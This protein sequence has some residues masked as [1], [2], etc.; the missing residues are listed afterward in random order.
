MSQRQLA[1]RLI[2]GVALGFILLAWFISGLEWKELWGVLKQVSL[3]WLLVA[4]VLMLLDYFFQAW[5]WG[6]L[7]RHVDDKISIKDLWNATAVMWAFNTLL[8]LRAGN[9]LRPALI[10][11]RRG[12]PYTTVL[13]T[14]VAEYIC[15]VF[16]ILIMLLT[17]LLFLP[18]SM[19]EQPVI[20]DLQTYGIFIAIG[21]LATFGV[22]VL[23]LSRQARNVVVGLLRPIPSARVQKKILDIFDQLVAGMAAVGDPLRF[24]QALGVTLLVWGAWLLVILATF[25]AFGLQMPFSGALFMEASLTLSMLVP[26]AP[27]FLGVFQVITEKALSLWGAS[28]AHGQGIALIF[29]AICFVPVTIIG[30]IAASREGIGLINRGRGLYE[31]LGGDG[32]SD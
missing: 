22:V 16:G 23:L 8:P 13:F 7:L 6:F 19:T 24:G 31:D 2:G 29:W 10:A 12:L 5:R 30:L 27:G 20:G 18:S 4:V 26:Q 15:D 3:G 32:N 9:F 25:R 21:G 14:M 11:R 1:I 28:S 17:M